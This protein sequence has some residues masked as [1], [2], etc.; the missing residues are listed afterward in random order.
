MM[1]HVFPARAAPF[2]HVSHLD[3]DADRVLIDQAPAEGSG[4]R[5]Q[6]RRYER[7]TQPPRQH[8]PFSIFEAQQ[9][10]HARQREHHDRHH[11]VCPARN[12]ASNPTDENEIEHACGA[13]HPAPARSDSSQPQSSPGPKAVAGQ[14]ECNIGTG[15]PDQGRNW[16]MD[17]HGVQWVPGEGYPA[18]NRVV[19]LLRH[20]LLRVNIR[21]VRITWARDLTTLLSTVPLLS[22]CEGPQSILDPAGPSA[23][24]A[25]NLWWGMFGWL[26]LVFVAVLAVWLVAVSRRG[27]QPNKNSAGRANRWIILGGIVLPLV[28]VT[29]ILAFG[30]PAGERMRSLPDGDQLIIEVTGHQWWW[31]VRYP[32]GGVETANQLVIPAGQP[33]Q[34]HAATGDVIHSFWVPRL[35]GKIDM[36]PGRTHVIPLEADEPGIYR[37]QCAEFCGA[38]HARM[39]LSVEALAPDDFADWLERRR[40]QQVA[41]PTEETLT[42]FR[43][44]CGDCHRVAGLTDGGLAP[45]LTDLASRAMLG[46]GTFSMSEPNAIEYWLREHQRLKPGNRMP[47][48]DELPAELLADIAAW[49]ETLAP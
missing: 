8:V 29:V 21:R 46:A 40:N 13:G 34:I 27:R 25:A 45:D 38:Q 20:L 12:Q 2:G 48:H 30:I 47:S 35:A 49:L 17:H 10:V 16:E 14:N 26:T 9:P 7:Q 28:T 11:A 44:H 22:G 18:E 36:V 32:D 24:L 15:K 43:R 6:H 4:C 1:N 3:I 41:M 5:D 42:G 23:R 19:S 31:Q 37:G 33:V 39:V